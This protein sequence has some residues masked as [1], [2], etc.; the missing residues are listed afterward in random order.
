MTKQLW[1][2]SHGDIQAKISLQPLEMTFLLSTFP[3]LDIQVPMDKAERGSFSWHPFQ[4]RAAQA[5]G[6]VT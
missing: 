3:C 6:K 2:V 1:E 5:T 4:Q